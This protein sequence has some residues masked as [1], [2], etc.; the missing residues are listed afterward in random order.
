MNKYIAVLLV[1]LATSC[2]DRKLEA[3]V[4]AKDGLDAAPCI[5]T[6]QVT[7]NVISCGTQSASIPKG[8]TILGFIFPCGTEFA[9]DEIFLRLSDGNI[10]MV[11]DGGDRLSRLA[12][13]VP[14]TYVTT[15][16][17]GA[18][19][20]VKVDSALNV[21]TSPTAATG[22]AINPINIR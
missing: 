18:Q 7:Q 1:A 16:R 9:N 22:L 17:T 21:I 20:T 14:M 5:I 15:D 4:T 6:E 3:T 10:L 8:I 12:L 2:A 11:Y 13:A 19:C